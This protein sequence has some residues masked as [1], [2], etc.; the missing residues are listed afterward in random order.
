MVFLT[1]WAGPGFVF[2]LSFVCVN[3]A[4]L[5]LILTFWTVQSITNS[6]W[7]ALAGT[8]V[9]ASF[10]FNI[11]PLFQISLFAMPFLIM[12]T[13]W[14]YQGKPWLAGM[15]LAL[16]FLIK[17]TYAF[18][19]PAFLVLFLLRQQQREA[20][21]VLSVFTAA[22]SFYLLHTF[23]AQPIPDPQMMLNATPPIFIHNL[24]G[25]LWFGF[26]VLAYNVLA[27][28]TFPGYYP[29]NPFPP[30]LPIPVFYGLL[31]AQMV[32]VWGIL[33]WWL[34]RHVKTRQ[35]PSI[36]LVV[37][38]VVLWLVPVIFTATTQINNFPMYWMDYAI[39]RWFAPSIVGF[40]I[41]VALSWS[42]LR[43]MIQQLLFPAP[44]HSS[45]DED[46]F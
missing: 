2:P 27:P 24:A 40:Q 33:G 36:P 16:A 5:N 43:P 7:A 23:I 3:I 25:F 38:A 34:F 42:D 9:Q 37:F 18:A 31:I 30:F 17:E 29:T 1:G 26:G 11:I 45:T 32:F 39:W 41:L 44:S 8:F 12:G 21:I 6:G 13:Y 20:G 14:A 15:S 10:F 22:V 19:L 28:A 46:W 4:A 35:V